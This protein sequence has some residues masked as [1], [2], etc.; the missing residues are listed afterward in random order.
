MKPMK[1]IIMGISISKFF[2]KNIHIQPFIKFFIFNNWS[3]LEF[4]I[5]NITDILG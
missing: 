1:I 3:G 4:L 5:L 2:V